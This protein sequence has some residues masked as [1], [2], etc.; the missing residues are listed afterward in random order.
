MQE[1]HVAK[2]LSPS[3]VVRQITKS[4]KLIIGLVVVG[5]LVGAAASVVTKPRWV[6]SMTVQIGQISAPVEAGVVSRPIENQLTASDRYNLPGLR[7]S[8]LKDLGLNPPDN[9]D[10]SSLLI[11]NTLMATPAR[12]P[13]LIKLQ[14]SAYSREQA[15]AALQASFNSFSDMHQKIYGPAV[16]ELKHNLADTQSRLK[17]AEKEYQ[18]A[19]GS[20]Q[21]ST[22]QGNSKPV[23]SRN[24]L[25]SNMVTQINL[26]V[27]Q[28]R[29]QVAE[30]EQANSPLLTY[31]TRIVEAPYAPLRANTPSRVVMILIGGFLGLLVGI[32]FAARRI[33][34]RG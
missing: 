23:D 1:M 22:G 28:L 26:Q 33:A 6:A 19:Y 18:Q 32:A 30:L 3:V 20:I 17:A 34:R 21:P 15:Q 24:V 31:P 11:F 13:D 7:L 4:G 5:A 12:G 29:S 9:G 14:V 10:R 8:V 16:D 27:L 25:V 2:S